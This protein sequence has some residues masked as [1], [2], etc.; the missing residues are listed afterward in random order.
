MYIHNYYYSY[1][2]DAGHLYNSL[3]LY[4]FYIIFTQSVSYSMSGFENMKPD[5]ISKSDIHIQI[6]K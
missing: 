4:K 5:I 3:E 1:I 6:A 2:D